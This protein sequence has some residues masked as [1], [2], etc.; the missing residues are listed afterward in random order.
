MRPASLLPVLPAVV[1][2]TRKL[3]AWAGPAASIAAAKAKAICLRITL[4]F[5]GGLAGTVFLQ[6]RGL[7]NLTA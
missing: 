3:V 5:V 7:I 1:V 6:K 2:D 4:S